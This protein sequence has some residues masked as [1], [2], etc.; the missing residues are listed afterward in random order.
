VNGSPEIGVFTFQQLLQSST[1]G[2]TSAPGLFYPSIRA[3]V[4]VSADGVEWVP[5]GGGATFAFDV[6]ANAYADLARAVASDYSRPFTGGLSALKDQPTLAATLAA[7]QGTGGGT[8]LDI[9]DTGLSQVG[10]VRF[11]VP[12][13][14]TFS[15]QLDA[16]S[17]S[18]DAVGATLPEPAVAALA[19]IAWTLAARRRR[20]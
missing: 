15:F 7:Y 11:S 2:T 6:P 3:A 20:N 5:L 4:D 18:A 12:Q 10:F 17:V 19:V 14:N 1:G 13:T 9:S 8:W 16:L